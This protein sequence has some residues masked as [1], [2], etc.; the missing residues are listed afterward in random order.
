MKVIDKHHDK[1]LLPKGVWQKEPDIRFFSYNNY[2]CLILRCY[3][4]GHLFGYVGIPLES[5][6][7]IEENYECL[8]VHG[9]VTWYKDRLPGQLDYPDIIIPENKFWIGFDCAHYGDKMPFEWQSYIPKHLDKF[10][11][12]FNKNDV[13]RNIKFVEKELIKL[14]DQ[15][16]EESV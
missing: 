12:L 9:G 2:P 5:K 10:Q 14:V 15:V 6:Y 7:T 8:I 1:S 13:Y 16:I 3:V 11:N 4:L